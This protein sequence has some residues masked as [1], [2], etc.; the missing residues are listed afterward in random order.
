[1]VRKDD[2]GKLDLTLNPLGL[3]EAGARAYTFGVEKYAR[4][5]YRSAYNP[6]FT[7]Q[8]QLA[9]A[10]RHLVATTN[11]EICAPDS[12]LDHLDHLVASVG[13]ALELKRLF[14][15]KVDDRW[16]GPLQ[17]TVEGSSEK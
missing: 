9:A 8:R 3:L 1:M 6:A 13:I 16:R 7:M 15:D 14:G 5:L 12:G 2:A 11:G 4:D 17:T 10:S